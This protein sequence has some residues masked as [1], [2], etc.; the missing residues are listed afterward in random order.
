MKGLFVTGIVYIF[1]LIAWLFYLNYDMAQFKRDL[2]IVSELP[3]QNEKTLGHADGSV[4]ERIS[5][6]SSDTHAPVKESTRDVAESEKIET[7]TSQRVSDA[8]TDSQGALMTTVPEASVSGL[9]LELEKIFI[10][11]KPLYDSLVEVAKQHGSLDIERYRAE[12][13]ISQIRSELSDT[14]NG[15]RR[16]ELY[17]EKQELTQWLEDSFPAY[18]A[19]EADLERLMTA[20][21]EFFTARGFSSEAEFWQTHEV[22]FVGW[23]DNQ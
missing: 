10:D 3:E 1:V 15:R 23:I 12:N 18:E 4:V 17:Y 14:R 16:Q 9:T 7:L 13:R 20:E 21:N 19:G 5:D 11:Y 6:H 8:T 22:T 2:L